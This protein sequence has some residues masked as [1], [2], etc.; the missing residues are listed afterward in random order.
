MTDPIK[1]FVGQ[2]VTFHPPAGRDRLGPKK[3]KV[4][5]VRGPNCVDVQTGEGIGAYLD[6]SV[7]YL[8]T[9][10]PPS[11]AHKGH[12]CHPGPAELVQPAIMGYRKLNQV[13][14]DLM[15]AIKMHGLLTQQ[16]IDRI[17]S[18]LAAQG[19]AAE[20][21]GNDGRGDEED[22]IHKAEPARWLAMGRTDLQV[23][24]MK[25]TRAV[26]QPGGF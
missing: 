20:L 25:L 8:P 17:G 3:A 23:G 2:D 1:P 6:T 7:L 9:S 12:W 5:K 21:E 19:A 22:R 26:A 18:H 13:E 24:L 10:E 14:A 11:A 16:L 15:N 4:V